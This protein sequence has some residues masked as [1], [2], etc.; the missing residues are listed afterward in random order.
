ML[1]YL[2]L[3]SLYFFANSNL[4]PDVISEINVPSYL[5]HWKQVYD[6]D[7]TSSLL[8]KT[9]QS[10]MAASRSVPYES[11]KKSALFSMTRLSTI[12]S[13][14]SLYDSDMKSA[15]LSKTYQSSMAVSWLL[16]SSNMKSALY[17]KTYQSSM[18]ASIKHRPI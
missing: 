14:L 17:S 8:S 1:S 5:G 13:P 12:A 10:S 3:A 18:A 6:S 4:L 7:M 2:L 15:L 16:Y 9:Y 11:E